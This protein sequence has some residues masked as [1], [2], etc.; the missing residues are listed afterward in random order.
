MA[1]GYRGNGWL[2]LAAFGL[3]L[4]LAVPMDAQNSRPKIAAP[5]AK[6]TQAARTGH[7]KSPAPETRRGADV[8]ELPECTVQK[9]I[10]LPGSHEYAG[11]FIEATAMEPGTD[12]Q[13]VF[14]ALTADL[15]EAVPA[16]KRAM[17]IS[18]TNDGGETWSAVARVGPGYFEARIGEGLRNGFIVAPGG[19]SFILTTQKGAFEVIS[20][21]GTVSAVILPIDG[22]R[23]PD[24]PPKVP[25]TKKPGEPV[26]ANVALMTTDGSTLY[27]GFGYFDRTPLL[28]RY[29]RGAGGNWVQ[30]RQITG[31]PSQ[32][33]LLSIQFD[34]PRPVKPR[35]MYVGTGDQAYLLNMGTMGWSRVDGVGTDS[36]IHGMSVV[37][38]LH[39]AAC[40]GVYNPVGPGMVSKVTSS[41]FLIHPTTDEAGPNVRAY[42]VDVDPARLNRVIVT[43]ITGV[44]VSEDGGKRWRRVN[45]L[46][47]G[48]YRTAHFDSDGRVLVSGM[49]GTFRVNPF[50]DACT[51]RLKRRR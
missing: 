31:L 34:D 47:D 39:I 12:D 7:R 23:V 2:G 18:K 50:S 38:G 9:V 22:P 21:P 27:L 14:W 5:A 24:E 51:P 20:Q 1:I 19:K 3:L 48:E 42:S 6:A 8:E 41:T 49:P 15:S 10:G 30:E 4:I 44:Y 25:L 40:W 36:A 13:D 17:Y 29:R 46:P 32:M 26:R 11:D 28:F 33:D 37:G 45:V 16:D 35:F 43:S